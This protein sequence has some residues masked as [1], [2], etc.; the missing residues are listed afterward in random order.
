MSYVEVA[1]ASEIAEGTSRVVEVNGKELILV[2][3]KNEF[4]AFNRRCTHM[5]G[6][7]SVGTLDGRIITCPRH[8]S[9]F[10]ITTGESIKGP[11]I[12]FVKL[13]TK[14]LPVYDVKV[15]D[16]SIRVKT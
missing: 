6:D 12:G 15:E 16:G 10:D 9:Q 8:G 14:N 5:G 13:R 3:Y 1:K 2:N 4:Y 11:K 7:L